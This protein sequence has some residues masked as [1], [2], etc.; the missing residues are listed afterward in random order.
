MS[1][2]E[3]RPPCRH[4]PRLSSVSITWNVRSVNKR[5]AFRASF[6]K[7]ISLVFLLSVVLMLKYRTPQAPK[8][9]AHKK[10]A[11]VVAQVETIKPPPEPVKPPEVMKPVEAPK[12][13]VK[14]VI[15]KAHRK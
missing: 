9:I 11:S 7:I 10:P 12:P 15:R 4:S 1:R 8:K 14:R 2:L 3:V 6:P 13:V 5:N